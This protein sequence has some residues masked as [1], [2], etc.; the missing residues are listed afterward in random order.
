MKNELIFKSYVCRGFVERVFER[1][2]GRGT[3][4]LNACYWPVDICLILVDIGGFENH[5]K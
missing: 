4:T 1:I 5:F 3:D 2:F